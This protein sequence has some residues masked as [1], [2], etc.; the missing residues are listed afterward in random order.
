MFCVAQHAWSVV[1]GQFGVM[2]GSSSADIR[3]NGT[4][5]SAV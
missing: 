3:L 2:V 1:P 5:S 4:V